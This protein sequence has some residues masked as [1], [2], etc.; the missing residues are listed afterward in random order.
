[1]SGKGA[2]LFAV[3]FKN[4]AGKVSSLERV[5][6]SSIPRTRPAA[7]YEL[8]ACGSFVHLYAWLNMLAKEFHPMLS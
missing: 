8:E 4:N 3:V 7:G 1:M 2:R 5:F 6:D